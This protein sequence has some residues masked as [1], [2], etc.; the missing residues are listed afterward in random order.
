MQTQLTMTV[1]DDPDMR[2]TAAGLPICTLRCPQMCYVALNKTAEDIAGVVRSG[3][4]LILHGYFRKRQWIDTNGVA[5]EEKDFVIR[6]WEK[7]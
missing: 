7:V 3:D 4:R 1:G 2:Y 5:Q 6:R